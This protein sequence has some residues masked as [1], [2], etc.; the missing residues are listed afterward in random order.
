[1][2][3]SLGDEVL[4]SSGIYGTVVEVDADSDRVT[5]D[6]G[7]GTRLVVAR[8]SI[9]RKVSSSGDSYYGSEPAE[10]D[11]LAAGGDVPGEADDRA[12][13]GEDAD[14]TDGEDHEWDES[15]GTGDEGEDGGKA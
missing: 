12:P 5:I 2:S 4:T 7:P 8:A 1:M 9:A 3:L 15:E 14:E 10:E 11:E 6:S 13:G